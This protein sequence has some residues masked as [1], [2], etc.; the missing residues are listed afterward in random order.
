MVG[1]L[2]TI[3]VLVCLFLIL[4]VL[5]QAG[6]GGG[7]GAAFGGASQTVFGGA[8]AGNFLTRLTVISAILFM[9][10]SA[11]LSYM[12]SSSDKSL[13]RATEALREIEELKKAAKEKREARKKAKAAAAEGTE[14]Q[15][16]TGSEKPVEA[17]EENPAGTETAPGAEAEL[18]D[19][20]VKTV[21]QSAATLTAA[22]G[23]KEAPQ[24]K[25]YEN[26]RA[27]GV[28]SRARP[29]EKPQE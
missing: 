19:A 11:T 28:Q 9:M 27:D 6:K 20:P 10:L 18:S 23:S 17:G 5:L 7:M 2:T 29:E 3:Y 22:P 15:E 4:V 24:N 1:F 26:G 12:A 16:A 25:R 21:P 13:D 14:E 8:G